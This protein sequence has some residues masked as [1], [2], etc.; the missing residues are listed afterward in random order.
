MTRHAKRFYYILL[1]AASTFCYAQTGNDAIDFLF[2]TARTQNLDILNS[3]RSLLLAQDAATRFW[4]NYSPGLSFSTA[5]T[6]SNTPLAT[7]CAPY[8]ASASIAAS[9]QLPGGVSLALTGSFSLAKQSI[10]A[11]QKH[12]FENMGYSDELSLYLSMQAALYS[13]GKEDALKTQLRLQTMQAAFNQTATEDAVLQQLLSLYIQLRQN[14]RNI[15]TVVRN[16]NFVQQKLD[17]T[18]E[19]HKVGSGTLSAVFSAE[20]EL[21]SCRTQCQSLENTRQEII[22][23]IEQLTGCSLTQQQIDLLCDTTLSLPSHPDALHSSDIQLALLDVQMQLYAVESVRMKQQYAPILS[24]STGVVGLAQPYRFENPF[25]FFRFREGLL[26]SAEVGIDLSPLFDA[27]KKSHLLQNRYSVI[28]AE[29]QIDA[30]KR[31]LTETYA[32]YQ[33]LVSKTGS[34][35]EEFIRSLERRRQLLEDTEL[36]HQQ[37][38]CT[39]L[40]LLQATT[41]Y[42]NM[43][44]TLANAD[45]NLW[46]MNWVLVNMH[47]N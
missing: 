10:D 18:T 15:N 28:S 36:L 24:V 47:V 2:D 30:R 9:Q 35:R 4:A 26:W 17:A 33:Q 7:M 29:E 34:Q 3:K 12:S 8:E 38:K 19:L 27:T 23:Q 43:Q 39:Q 44:D 16:I 31:S 20:D 40:E 22:M 46:F 37:G 45:D 14:Q 13:A 41:S 6:F 1:I 5:T 21:Y 11:L 25:S 42:L 32:H